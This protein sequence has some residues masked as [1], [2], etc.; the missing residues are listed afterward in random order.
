MAVTYVCTTTQKPHLLHLDLDETAATE[1][2]Y[3]DM[4]TGKVEQTSDSFILEKL[5]EARRLTSQAVASLG[6][7]LP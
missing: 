2:T 5:F 3:A 4:T 6:A 7:K 1:K